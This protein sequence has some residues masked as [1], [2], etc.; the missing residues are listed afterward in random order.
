MSKSMRAFLVA[1]SLA[2]PISMTYVAVSGTSVEAAGKKSKGG[3]KA[4]K[5]V[6]SAKASK[7]KASPKVAAYKSC[8]T[9]MYWKGGKCLDARAKAK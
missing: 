9:F 8:G 7:A 2:L 6:K 1:C 5:K 3:K 4:A